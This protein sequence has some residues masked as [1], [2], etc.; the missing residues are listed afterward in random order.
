[1]K[2][3]FDAAGDGRTA[4]RKPLQ[5]R[6]RAMG[7]IDDLKTAVAAYLSEKVKIT[8][9][10]LPSSVVEGRNFAFSISVENAG[11]LDM[12]NVFVALEETG[13]AYPVAGLTATTNLHSKTFG[14]MSILSGNLVGISAFARANANTSGV[15]KPILNVHISDW[16]AGLDSILKIASAEG[17]EKAVAMTISKV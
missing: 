4:R 2:T 6:K 16:D 7:V 9:Q 13:F 15:S 3:W 5:E 17:A 12:N 11:A 14:P 10:S 8:F 1:M